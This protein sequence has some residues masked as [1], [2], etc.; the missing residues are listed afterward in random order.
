MQMTLGFR[1]GNHQGKAQLWPSGDPCPPRGARLQ[2]TPVAGMLAQVSL[3]SKHLVISRE[4]R[5]WVFIKTF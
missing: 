4:S 1:V 5:Y 2:L 3:R